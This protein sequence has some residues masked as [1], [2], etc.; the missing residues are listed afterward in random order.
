MSVSQVP[1]VIS[2]DHSW[3]ITPMVDHTDRI[4]CPEERQPGERR[5]TCSLLPLYIDVN[6]LC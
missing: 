3:S 2:K 1:Y 6:R 5:S 4:R